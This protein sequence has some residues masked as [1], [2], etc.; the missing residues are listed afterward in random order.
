MR[1][2]SITGVLLAF[3]IF[4]AGF[5]FFFALMT[6]S[7]VPALPV[8]PAAPDE[9]AHALLEVALTGFI[10]FRPVYDA[11]GATIVDLTYEYLNPAAQQMLRLPPQPAE[12][13]LTLFPTAAAQEGVFNFY[14]DTFLSGELGRHQFNYQY[15]GLDGYFHLAA[16]RQG[17]RLVVSFTDTN[18]QSRTP[19][20]EALRASQAR[21]Q[22]AR[23]EIEHQKS[24]LQR[25]FVEAPVAIAWLQGLEHIIEFANTRMAQIWDRPLGLLLGRPHFEALPDIAG[26]GFEA[27]LAGVL[28]SG[29]PY[30]LLEQ[31]ITINKN[32]GLYRG[33][34]NVTYQPVRDGQGQVTGITASAVDVTDQVQA[35]Q[36]VEEQ[37]RRTNLLNEELQAA[38]E[39]ILANNHE[40]E[41]TQQQMR[42]FNEE[43]EARVARR[44]QQL[45]AATQRL[46]QERE[47]FYQILAQTPAAICIMR[48]PEHRYEYANAAYCQLLAGHTFLGRALPE[49]LLEIMPEPAARSFTALLDEVYRT[50]ETYYGYETPFRVEPTDGLPGYLAYFNFTY[51]A[52]REG[53]QI[54]GLSVFAYEVTELVQAK[55][56]REAQQQ[57]VENVFE[58]SP[59]PLFVMRGPTHIL[60]VVNPMAASLIGY[61]REYLLGKPYA[62]AVPDVKTLGFE[63]LLRQVWESGEAL[64]LHEQPAHLSYHQPGEV[65][66]YSFV[67]QPLY[68]EQGRVTSIACVATEVTDQVRARQQ[69]QEL[70]EELAVINEELTV[71]NEELLGTNQQLT[72]T[73]VDLDNFIYTASH[74]LRQPISNIEGLL[75]LLNEV[76]PEASRTNEVVAGVL[77]RMLD[78]VERFKRTITNLTDVSKLQL[79][80]A[81]PAVPVLLADVVE[82]VRLD[83]LPQL[84]ETGAQLEVDVDGCQP[85]VFSEKNLRSILY[86][87]LSNALKYRHADRPPH[88]RIACVVQGKRLVLSVQ[89]NGLGVDEWQQARLFQLFQRLHT[90]VEGSGLGLYMVKKIVENAGGTIEVQSQVNVGTT[91]TIRFPV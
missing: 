22:A 34:F 9:L 12:S 77:T 49:L 19:V 1:V 33:Y 38:N 74:D 80:F 56:Q 57:L 35:R 71:A 28:Q 13:F 40:L 15:D 41:R 8:A 36:V 42:Q 59:T 46:A 43:L 31:P 90:H 30:Y 83:L 10:L 68:D 32:K 52:Y 17:P 21:E 87:L 53:G 63:K 62:E 66:Y 51:S 72:R 86:N 50:G 70:N 60:E 24:E 26:Q 78:S 7:M 20:E 65:G 39:E 2:P 6:H 5:G 55:Q 73:N 25:M 67:Y 23:A 16:W 82:D 79:E 84:T 14:R 91:F 61:P 58:H 85:R 76:L 29:Q 18:N 37:E 47:S 48:G 54:I 75:N 3:N 64:T 44:T 4:D 81:Q 89:D 45:E 27:I 69:V 88:I 11:A